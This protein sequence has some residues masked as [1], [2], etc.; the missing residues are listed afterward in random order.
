MEVRG[1]LGCGGSGGG[2][3]GLTERVSVMGLGKLFWFGL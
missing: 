3:G 2:G 1:R